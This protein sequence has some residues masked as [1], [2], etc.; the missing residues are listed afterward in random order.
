MSKKVLLHGK[1]NVK[2]LGSAVLF[3][4]AMDFFQAFNIKELFSDAL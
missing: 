4:D 3:R 2:T 1:K